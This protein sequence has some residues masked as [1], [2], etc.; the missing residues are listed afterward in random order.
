LKREALRVTQ[1]SVPE[2]IRS[3][4]AAVQTTPI[5]T[6]RQLGEITGISPRTL[7][8]EV[9]AGELVAFRRGK[10]NTGGDYCVTHGDAARYICRMLSIITK[11]N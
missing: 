10:R 7:R 5:I 6:L 8:R 4:L 9:L 1:I 2:P 3:F 11:E